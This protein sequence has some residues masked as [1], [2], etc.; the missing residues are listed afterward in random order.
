MIAHLDDAVVERRVA[1]SRLLIQVRRV[2]H[3]EVD[4]VERVAI[5][6]PRD[7]VVQTSFRELL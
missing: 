6:L 7:G 5:V 2:L 4:D 1:L 3:Q